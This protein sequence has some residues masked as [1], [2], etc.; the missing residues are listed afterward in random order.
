MALPSGPGA[1]LPPAPI[2]FHCLLPSPR[3]LQLT[4]LPG[5]RPPRSSPPQPVSHPQLRRALLSLS[6]PPP[7]AASLF[8]PSGSQPSSPPSVPPSP[9]PVPSPPALLPPPL[10]SPSPFPPSLSLSSLPT[11]LPTFPSWREGRTP[12]SC[13]PLS[14]GRRARLRALPSAGAAAI[15]QDAGEE[16][17][18]SK[19]YIFYEAPPAPGLEILH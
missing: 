17:V 10:R 19:Q 5:P 16:R 18:R 12:R 9:P 13:H 6:A 11:S 3:P 1:A 8:P 2:F 7:R 15:L 4:S 14:L